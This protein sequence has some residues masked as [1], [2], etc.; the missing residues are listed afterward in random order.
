MM[1]GS[2]KSDRCVVPVKSVNKAERS[3][4]ERME[5]RHLVEG[6]PSREARSGHRTGTACHL[7][8]SGPAAQLHGS[9]KPRTAQWYHPRQ[10]PGAG[11]PH[12]GICAGGGEQ[13]PSLPRPRIKSGTAALLAMTSYRSSKCPV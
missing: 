3:A 1:H 2:E 12:A 10:E 6:R 5:G 13:S 11:K 7:N 9:L 4:A 8:R